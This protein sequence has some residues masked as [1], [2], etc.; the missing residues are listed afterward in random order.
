[1]SLVFTN[2]SNPVTKRH[3]TDIEDALKNATWVECSRKGSGIAWAGYCDWWFGG[4]SLGCCIHGC[5]EVRWSAWVAGLKKSD[6]N[7]WGV[8][9][10]YGTLLLDTPVP[11]VED[12]IVCDGVE[13]H[14]LDMIIENEAAFV[15]GHDPLFP[16]GVGANMQMSY[17]D[18]LNPTITGLHAFLTLSAWAF[19]IPQIEKL[20][21]ED[22]IRNVWM[23][24][25]VDGCT[26]F[27]ENYT[28]YYDI[29]GFH[30]SFIQTSNS[31]TPQV[32]ISLYGERAN[33]D[34]DYL[35]T[36]AN[37][38]L[39][40]GNWNW[41]E[42]TDLALAL[43]AHRQGGGYETFGVLIAPEKYAEGLAGRNKQMLLGIR[44]AHSSFSSAYFTHPTDPHYS[45]E[46]IDS[47]SARYLTY[48]AFYIGRINMN[49]DLHS[50]THLEP[51][52]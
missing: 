22:T 41:I 19:V 26:T 42:I 49:A 17:G 48:G 44:Q 28:A 46:F 51:P 43:N 1:M 5:G 34:V 33:G 32:A 24:V 47:A 14:T 52:Y 37:T 16:N 23:Q 15:T 3:L 4:T 8:P 9:N 29:A 6:V 21:E 27:E 18:P 38:V 7:A 2:R 31:T 25:K 45:Q 50:L 13:N 39:A 11:Q 10:P 36:S 12:I 30:S 20:S 40:D 35:F